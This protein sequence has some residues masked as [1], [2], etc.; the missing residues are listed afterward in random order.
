VQIIQKWRLELPRLVTEEFENIIATI[1]AY[2]GIEHKDD[3]THGDI[4]ADSIT[5]GGV[6]ITPGAGGGPSTQTFLTANTEPTLPNHRKLAA[7]ANVALDISTPGWMVIS[8]AGGGTGGGMNLDYLGDF[9]PGPVYN[10]GDIVIGAD[11]IAYMCVVDGTTTPPEPWPGVGVAVNATVDASYWVVNPHAALTNERVMSSLANGYVKSTGGEPSTVAIIPVAEGGTGASTPTNARINLGVGTVGPVNLNGNAATF[12]NG[13]GAW[14]TP[15]QAAG[16]PSGSIIFFT[17]PCPPGYTRVAAWD[18]RYVRMGP[19][20]TTGG[21]AS[22][23]HGPGTYAP[24][25]HTHTDGTYSVA[26]HQHGAGSLVVAS[27]NHGNVA[28][29]GNTGNAG[30]HAHSYSG[31]TGGESNGSSVMDAGGGMNCVR[32][33]HTH[34]FAGSTSTAGDHNHSFSGSGATGSASPDVNGNTGSSTA[35][36]VGVSG[37]ASV[38]DMTGTS[39]AR[40][41]DPLYVDFFACQKD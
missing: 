12:L 41:N 24:A 34:A 40:A 7:G 5:I 22:H 14:T 25:A 9:A 29:S 39:D 16:V 35:D 19:S 36:V 26:N 17:T 32:A 31:T 23:S 4:H 13:T 20:H 1:R 15:P 33:P 2:W 6:P 21:A 27:H 11:G 28:I 18:G 3:G 30:D 8:A 37:P 10:D 38:L